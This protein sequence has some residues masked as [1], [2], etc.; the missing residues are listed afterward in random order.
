MRE[1]SIWIHVVLSACL[2]MA[3]AGAASSQTQEP[4]ARNADA[5][6]MFGANWCAPCLEELRNLPELAAATAP[7]R[8]LLAWRDGSP[9]PLWPA[10]P[11]NVDIKPSAEIERLVGSKDLPAGLPYA[12]VLDSKGE[13]CAVLNGKLTRD[14]IARLRARCSI[15]N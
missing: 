7:G 2:A 9:R 12:V 6:I 13:R 3:C 1:L 14:R 4:R 11:A 15:D 5:V 8:L 10:W